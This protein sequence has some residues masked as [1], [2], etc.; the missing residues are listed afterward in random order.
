LRPGDGNAQEVAVRAADFGNSRGRELLGFVTRGTMGRR[1]TRLQRQCKAR[2]LEGFDHYPDTNLL[3][4]RRFGAALGCVA[5]IAIAFAGRDLNREAVRLVRGHRVPCPTRQD[6]PSAL[7]ALKRL[8]TTAD[9][10]LRPGALSDAPTTAGCGL[11]PGASA[12]AT[13]LHGDARRP[14]TH[15]YAALV[16]RTHAEAGFFLHQCGRR[17][18]GAGSGGEFRSWA[19]NL[20]GR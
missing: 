20:L 19:K 8:P 13:P 14:S 16:V 15:Y 7:G 11:R 4:G 5:W 3:G 2:C 10:G 17:P 6:R 9:G 1:L 18:S 12:E